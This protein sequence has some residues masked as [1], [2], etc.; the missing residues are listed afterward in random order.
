VHQIYQDQKGFI[1]MSTMNGLNVFDGYQFRLYKKGNGGMA[2]NVVNCVEQNYDNKIYIGL[3]NGLQRFENDT[4]E[5]VSWDNDK[6]SSVSCYINCLCISSSGTILAGSS[7]H[8]GLIEVKKNGK[9]HW[10]FSKYKFINSVVKMMVDKDHQLWM[11][12]ENNGIICTKG[13]RMSHFFAKEGQNDGFTDICQDAKGDIYTANIKGGLYRMKY[14]TKTFN[15]IKC[16]QTLPIASLFATTN[17]IILLGTNGLGLIEY[18]PRYSCTSSRN[19]LN[20]EIDLKRG[21]IYSILEDKQGN[22]WTGLLQKGVFLQPIFNAGFHYMGYRIGETN[23]IGD[24]CLNNIKR[25]VDGTLW[26]ATDGDGLFSL[27]ING[28]LKRHYTALQVPAAILGIDEDC[29]GRLWVGSYLEGCGWIDR[30][31]GKYHRLKC[32]QKGKAQLVF[33]VVADKRG[34]LWIGT[35]GAGLLCVDLKTLTPIRI[36]SHET[37]R[38]YS[39]T[40]NYIQQLTMSTDDTNLYVSTT[41]GL[42]CINTITGKTLII[43]GSNNLLRNDLNV[44][45]AKDDT[46][47]RLWV[48]TPLGLY[49]INKNTWLKKLITIRDGLADD[50]T[51]SVLIDKFNRAWVSTSHGLSCID[52]KTFNIKNYYVADGLQGNE[53]NGGVSSKAKD[54]TMYFGG[55]SGLT[56]FDPLKIKHRNEKYQITITGFL[57]GNSNI[58]AGEK[59]GSYTITDKA[60]TDS[61]RFDLCYQ[62]NSFTVTLSTLSY[63]NPERV[64]FFYSVNNERWIRLQQGKNALA[65]SHTEPG[66]YQ[67][68]IKAQNMDS[69]SSILEFRVCIHPAWYATIWAKLTYI[70][71]IIL[72]L[73]WYLSSRKN[74]ERNKL[75]LQEH[76]HAEELSEAKLKFFINISHEIRTPVTLITAPLQQLLK[77]DNDPIRHNLYEII[78]RNSERLSNL[79]NQMMDLRKIDK[80][81]MHMQMQKTDL[82]KY[83][84]NVV[85]LFEQQAK[86]KD[87]RLSYIHDE[88]SLSVWIDCSHFDKI[89]INLLSNAFK[90]TQTGGHVTTEVIHGENN[91]M[92]KVSDDGE[93]IPEEKINCIF[94]RFYQ[95]ASITNYRQTGTGIGLN[96]ARSLVELHHGTITVCNNVDAEGCTFTVCIPLGNNHLNKNEICASDLP[97]VDVTQQNDVFSEHINLGPSFYISKTKPSIVIAEDEEDIRSYIIDQLKEEYNIIDCKNGKEAL[98]AIL[99]NIPQLVI[100]DIMMPVMDGNELCI[101]IKGNINTNHIP[102]ILLTAKNQD[103]DKLMSLEAGADVYMVKPFNMDILRQTIGNLINERHILQN[104]FSGNEYQEDKINKI[105]VKSPDDYLLERVMAVINDNLTNSDINI[106][107][108]ADEV[109]ISRVHLHRKLKELTNQTPHELIRNIRL[110]QAA[111]LLANGN[112]SIAGVMYACGYTN[113]TSFARVFRQMY[114]ITPSDYMKEHEQMKKSSSK[115]N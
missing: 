102:V 17:N 104:K 67:F 113:A 4:F 12:T 59:S 6:N 72:S 47:D 40:N 92:I 19:S 83:T 28:N 74:K 107:Q 56:W 108:I 30:I 58:R 78:R 114:G 106:E 115:Q 93:N 97:N 66:T 96:L 5:N 36:Y 73:W 89:I 13:K 112:Q 43:A 95:T 16:T 82:I 26:V 39:L 87:I 49:I 71:F 8:T 1:W 63:D 80:G 51:A 29:Y 10:I 24:E 22:I 69:V 46:A 9:A 99:K 60:V 20:T 7:S 45:D 88:E 68:K 42:S 57:V 18:N 90:Y 111:N 86:I 101:K 54:G 76:I 25:T 34:H 91:A 103:D 85:S 53:F 38:D 109:G 62:D 94:E 3:G 32:T 81:Q 84:Q 79:I 11:L 37:N 48:C 100:S 75:R 41:S 52:P 61:R 21:K 35:M 65:F 110:K 14:G 105:S 55:M 44:L 2:G 23:S 27:D 50:N 64:T 15:M 31:T 98:T 77:I 33:D 70:I